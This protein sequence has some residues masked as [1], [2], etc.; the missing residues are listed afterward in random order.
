MNPLQKNW[1]SRENS[2]VVFTRTCS[3]GSYHDFLDSGL[4]LTGKLLSPWFPVAKWKSS[5]RK[6][7]RNGTAQMFIW[8][9]IS[10]IRLWW[11]TNHQIPY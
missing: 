9:V 7:I 5:L 2:N 4:V 11:Y 10:H 1:E 6:I 8:N 3:F